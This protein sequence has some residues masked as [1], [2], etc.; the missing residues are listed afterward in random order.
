[1]RSQDIVEVKETS[2]GSGPPT[3]WDEG[4]WGLCL[5]LSEPQPSDSLMELLSLHPPLLSSSVSKPVCPCWTADPAVNSLGYLGVPPYSK[6]LT[7]Q[8]HTVPGRTSNL[9]SRLLFLFQGGAQGSENPA[10]LPKA[11]QLYQ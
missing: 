9:R 7:L 10:H 11:A 2:V 8:E 5:L 4:G 3:S 1:M 6:R